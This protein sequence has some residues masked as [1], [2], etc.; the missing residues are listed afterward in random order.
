MKY[1]HTVPLFMRLGILPYE[2]ILETSQTY[3]HALYRVRYNYAP[4]VLANTWL[5]TP[6]FYYSSALCPDEISSPPVGSCY[7]IHM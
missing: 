6:T 2:K 5:K 1:D 7:C 3:V 4:R